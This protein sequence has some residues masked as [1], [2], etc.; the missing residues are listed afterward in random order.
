MEHEIERAL[1]KWQGRPPGDFELADAL[2]PPDRG[3]FYDLLEKMRIEGRLVRTRRGGWTL[4]RQIGMAAGKVQRHS[5]GFAFLIQDD[6][7]EEDIFIPAAQL[8][9]AMHGDR[10]LVTLGRGERGDRRAEAE[11]REVLS[12]GRSRIVGLFEASDSGGYVT[13]DDTRIGMDLFIPRHAQGGAQSGMKVVAEITRWPEGQRGP[14]GRVIEVL[15]SAADVGVDILSIIREMGLPDRFPERVLREAERI[16]QTVQPKA[17]E[18]RLDLRGQVVFTIDGADAKDLDDAVSVEPLPGDGWR[19]GVHIADVSSYVRPG[20]A[21]DEEAF[22]RGTSVYLV[23]RVVPMLPEALSNGICSLNPGVDRLTLSCV[24]DITP[25]GEVKDF[26]VSES[27]IRS[28]AHMT[29]DDVNRVLDANPDACRE[30]DTLAPHFTQMARLAQALNARRMKRGS[31]ELDIDEAYIEVDDEGKP[32]N[33][34]PRERG[35]S[36]R[37][38]EEFM[39]C[40]NETVAAWL[41]NMGMPAVY[42]IHE[43]PDPDKMKELALFAEFLGHRLSVRP[44]DVQPGDMQALLRSAHNTPEENILSRIVLRSM[45]KARYSPENKGH[46]GLAAANYCH[47]TSPIRRYPDLFV[48]RVVHAVLAGSITP[49]WLEAQAVRA[50]EAARQSSER[51]IAA[52]EAERA[53]DDLKMTEYMSKHVGEVFDAIIS[54][55]TEFGLF[56]ELPSTVEGLV[57]MTSLDD[58]YYIYDEKR[59]CLTGRRTRRTYR[60]GDPVQ[61][62]CMGTDLAQ[63]RIEFEM[64]D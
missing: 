7:D 58:D 2:H 27:V 18:G 57:R 29:Y 43:N 19:L 25:S 38:I 46:F 15:G 6:P 41:W 39:L 36:H 51:E 37:M 61:V 26:A 32:V 30:Y 24:M 33:I 42:R 44:G 13:P 28:A 63:R 62:E 20:T 49:S 45:R 59:Y 3:E 48:H 60:L 40:A 56:V 8:N 22:A 50:A 35:A 21:L 53:A 52:Q 16:P 5:R 31:L 12:H 9:G 47:F 14:A 17:I 34:T 4:P 54:G 64:A 55:V 1:I 10:V 11:V 23:D